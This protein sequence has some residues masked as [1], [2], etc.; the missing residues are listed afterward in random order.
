MIV[1]EHQPHDDAALERRAECC[2]NGGRW[3]G[4][5]PQVVDGVVDGLGRAIEKSGNPC[6]DRVC[7][8]ATI[9]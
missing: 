1:V 8:L 6:C 3:A 4:L 2:E 7:G 5:E 9:R